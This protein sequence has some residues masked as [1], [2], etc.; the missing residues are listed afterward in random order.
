[1]F[2]YTTPADNTDVSAASRA[3]ASLFFSSALPSPSAQYSST[4]AVNTNPSNYCTAAP[5]PTTSNNNEPKDVSSAANATVFTA[6]GLSPF[7]I[8]ATHIGALPTTDTSGVPGLFS[9]TGDALAHALASSPI[10]STRSSPTFAQT[11]TA[12]PLAMTLTRGAAPMTDFGDSVDAITELHNTHQAPYVPGGP[13]YVV[14]NG[15]SRSSV[16]GSDSDCSY[17]DDENEDEGRNSIFEESTGTS[18]QLPPL[19]PPMVST[20]SFSGHAYSLSNS[21]TLSNSGSPFICSE[22]GNNVSVRVDGNARVLANIT[23][24]QRRLYKRADCGQHEHACDQTQGSDYEISDC[25]QDAGETVMHTMKRA[26]THTQLRS[27]RHPPSTQLQQP[28]QHL[29]HHNR[30]I[31]LEQKHSLEEIHSRSQNNPPMCTQNTKNHSGGDTGNRE[32]VAPRTSRIWVRSAAAPFPPPR[33]RVHANNAVH[34]VAHNP[35]TNTNTT[36]ANEASNSVVSII[37]GAHVNNGTVVAAVANTSMFTP[38]TADAHTYAGT[39]TGGAACHNVTSTQGHVTINTS[40]HADDRAHTSLLKGAL[41]DACAPLN[42]N[43]RSGNTLFSVVGYS[44]DCLLV[45]ATGTNASSDN[46]TFTA[47]NSSNVDVAGVSAVSSQIDYNADEHEQK[48]AKSQFSPVED[49]VSG[50]TGGLSTKTHTDIRPRAIT[51]AMVH[52]ECDTAALLA[53]ATT[54][55]AAQ[56]GDGFMSITPIANGDEA[57]D[58]EFGAIVTG[59]VGVYSTVIGTCH[60]NFDS[61]VGK[62]NINQGTGMGIDGM[63][64]SSTDR[65][66]VAFHKAEA[67]GVAHT[68]KFAAH[69]IG[70]YDEESYSGDA[71]TVDTYNEGSYTATALNQ[72]MTQHNPSTSASAAATS[73]GLPNNQTPHHS[74]VVSTE[75]LTSDLQHYHNYRPHPMADTT[76][77]QSH[78]KQHHAQLHQQQRQQGE[79]K[80]S[81]QSESAASAATSSNIGGGRRTLNPHYQEFL[82]SNTQFQF[83]YTSA[84]RLNQHSA[85]SEPNMT[86]TN[87]SGSFAH[88]PATLPA[89][90]PL[91]QSAPATKTLPASASV[92]AS[93][94]THALAPTAFEIPF[95]H[96]EEGVPRELAQQFSTSSYTTGVAAAGVNSIVTGLPSQLPVT[97]ITTRYPNNRSSS[98]TRTSARISSAGSSINYS[99]RS[100]YSRRNST[101]NNNRAVIASIGANT[102]VPQQQ[103]AFSMQNQQPPLQQ[104]HY[105]QQQRLP[106]AP[107]MFTAPVHG[108]LV[109]TATAMNSAALPYA[110]ANGSGPGTAAV[111]VA[112]PVARL[113][114]LVSINNGVKRFHCRE[115]NKVFSQ[116]GG[117]HIH[118]RT[119]TNQR[120]YVC[121]IC[122]AA[123]SQA[124]NL[125]R[126]VR[127]HTGEKPWACPVCNKRFNR[128]FSVAKHIETQHA[129]GNNNA[130]SAGAG[131]NNEAN[132]NGKKRTR[133][134]TQAVGATP[135]VSTSSGLVATAAAAAAGTG[136]PGLPRAVFDDDDDDDDEEEEDGEEYEDNNDQQLQQ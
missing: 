33:S 27:L 61:S 93:A 91:P 62:T 57:Y 3:T 42:T 67:S 89:P 58:S 69:R 78:I 38:A 116:R 82:N 40:P 49:R 124:C 13:G 101:G 71:Y 12:F 96:S 21:S 113:P 50:F 39:T 25:Q 28:D 75:Q 59:A 79:I 130:A 48:Y 65:H 83:R 86:T 5:V 52:Q 110:R 7:A 108:N 119:H 72:S 125:K 97:T 84:N 18:V 117:L 104:Q 34:G 80:C 92:P 111:L 64:T 17:A 44:A 74:G 122:Q 6:F 56:L 70:A 98:T 95:N 41:A 19:P 109:H 63:Y 11:A 26:R 106:Y 23:S 47:N 114:L 22:T 32:D 53:P 14:R 29:G 132:N 54:T 66:D 88:L 135:A 120:P 126:H 45:N 43:S 123:F 76:Q 4:F 90:V 102:A 131:A 73:Q 77:P 134:G 100:R 118:M 16:T 9:P 68:G 31:E 30:V 37:N 107:S 99:N 15:C 81:R 121:D 20:Q 46:S 103:N 85:G 94:S 133:G 51:Y 128:K 87:N 115:C 1:M 127:G 24:D 60:Q 8:M 36:V 2:A 10:F 55:E 105:H 136:G 129:N 35:I 112:P